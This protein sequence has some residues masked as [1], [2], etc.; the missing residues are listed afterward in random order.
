MNQSQ[1]LAE[2]KPMLDSVDSAMERMFGWTT[3]EERRE[4]LEMLENEFLERKGEDPAICAH[5]MGSG[6]GQHDG[7]RCPVCSGRGT[8]KE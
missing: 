5:C 4:R 6:E 1:F 7:T 2:S 3:E 8:E